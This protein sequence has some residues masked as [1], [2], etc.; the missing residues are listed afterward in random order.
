MARRI[1]SAWVDK[2][3]RR[4]LGLKADAYELHGSL[5]AWYGSDL[6]HEHPQ[7]QNTLPRERKKIPA[8]PGLSAKSGQIPPTALVGAERLSNR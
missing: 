6:D 7:V 4:A 1:V 8:V 3:K 2:G 5:D